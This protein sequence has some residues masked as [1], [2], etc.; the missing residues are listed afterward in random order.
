MAHRA[1][2]KTE[3]LLIP[4]MLVIIVLMRFLHHDYFILF[5]HLSKELPEDFLRANIESFA[6]ILVQSYEFNAVIFWH[7]VFLHEL[8]L[9]PAV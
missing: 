3:S 4:F 5:D 6:P 9:R 2:V 8:I 1:R 7:D